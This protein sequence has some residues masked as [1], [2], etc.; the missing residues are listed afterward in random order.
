MYIWK[1]D[2]LASEIKENTLSEKDWKD[3]FLAS[4]IL[5]TVSM[6]MLQTMPR[7]NMFLLMI[8]AILMIAIT[9]IGINIAFNANQENSGTN[10]VARITA[11]SFPLSIKIIATS[12]VFGIILGF[13]NEMDP[14]S[15]ENEEWAYTAFTVLIQILFFWRIKIHL[16]YINT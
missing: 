1:T 10:F 16:T 2:K 8:E 6:Y 12:F 14:I 15:T 5:I 13:L 7:T 11:L 9:V 3:Y 4:A